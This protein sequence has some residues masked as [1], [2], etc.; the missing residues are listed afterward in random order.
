MIV[1]D[2]NLLLY[3][4]DSESPF[5]ERAALW[6]QACLSGVEPVGLCAAV[7]LAFVRIGTSRK[8]YLN[9]MSVEEAAGCVRSWLTRSVTD[10]LAAQ[11]SDL[12]RAL[13]WIEAAGSGGN[14]TTDAQIAAIATRHRA[15]VHT[16]DTDFDRFSGVRWKNPLLTR[17]PAPGIRR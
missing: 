3:A 6:W 14:L 8:A 16:A 9:P 4:Y 2:A 7:L 13:E 1:P 15:T 10:F 5:H 17:H 12:T 11:E